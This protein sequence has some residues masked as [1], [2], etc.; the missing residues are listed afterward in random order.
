[1]VKGWK[2]LLLP[3]LVT[4]CSNASAGI[5]TQRLPI[6]LADFSGVAWMP[7]GS[8]IVSYN[9]D[10]LDPLSA[11]RL[12]RMQPNGR[13]LSPLSITV[14]S[15]CTKESFLNPSALPDGRLGF[16][17]TCGRRSG[18]Q[19]LTLVAYDVN[20]GN[21]TQLVNGPLNLSFGQFTWNPSLTE[22]LYGEVGDPC[23]GIVGLTPKGIEYLPVVI[24]DGASSWS[25]DEIF[26]L[27]EGDC[28]GTGQA[29]WP[30][31][32]PDGRR[33]GFLAS[34]AAIGSD[35]L[36][37]L[38]APWNLYLMDSKKQVPTVVLTG[39]VHPRSLVWSPDNRF[40]ALSGEVRG[41]EATWLFQ[42]ETGAL[43]ILT[44]TVLSAIAWD[45]GGLGMVG[46]HDTNSGQWPPKTEI[47]VLRFARKM[48]T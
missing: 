30:A 16:L 18:S 9:S 8:I 38:D 19:E 25:L 15:T 42:P 46:L 1:M 33:I 21:L 5:T 7:G 4:A 13:G 36:S 47:L 41:E 48:F 2:I 10:P 37:R 26:R 22:G 32:S 39:I 29:S 12:W 40:L 3:L 24:K 43:K 34:S 28:A 23:V 17:R 11:P 31:W 20:S 14:E 6:P 45:P 35:T 27:R 44:R